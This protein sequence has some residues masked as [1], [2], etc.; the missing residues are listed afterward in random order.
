MIMTIERPRYDFLPENATSTDGEL[1]FVPVSPDTDSEEE[2]GGSYFDRYQPVENPPV[3]SLEIRRQPSVEKLVVEPVKQE[4]E[5]ALL[6]VTS[7]AFIKSVKALENV[8][9]LWC[10]SEYNESFT[11]SEAVVRRNGIDKPEQS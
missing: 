4:P 9:E 10:A 2:V 11:G 7:Q 1:P 8:R 6:S 5:Y 3:Q